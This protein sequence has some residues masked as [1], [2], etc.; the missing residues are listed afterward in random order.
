MIITILIWIY[1]ALLAFV[2]GVSI[3]D[4]F[5]KS[6]RCSQGVEKVSI[7]IIMLTGLSGITLIAEVMNFFIN[8]GWLAQVILLAGAILLGWLNWKKV[9]TTLTGKISGLPWWIFIFFALLTLTVLEF[10]T[11]SPINPDTSIYHAQAIRWIETYPVVPGLGNLHTRLALD[12]TWL[13]LNA[14][15][16][17]RFLGGPSF[18]VLP[19]AFVMMVLAF[20]LEGP[21]R[22]IKKTFSQADI[23]KTILIPILFHILNLEISSPG[24]DLP[25]TLLVWVIF[26]LWLEHNE[27]N[28]GNPREENIFTTPILFCF[29]LWAVTIKLSTL[30]LLL[31]CLIILIFFL[32]NR[33]QS[34]VILVTLIFIIFI[35]WLI[36]NFILSG[37]WIYPLPLVAGISPNADWKI[38]LPEV[39]HLSRVIQ[40]WARLPRVDTE[41]VLAMPLFE[42]LKIW[43][44]SLHLNQKLII[45]GAL[46]SPVLFSLSLLIRSIDKVERTRLTICYLIGYLGL[47]FWLYAGPDIRFGYGFIIITPLIA[48]VPFLHLILKKIPFQH[49]VAVSFVGLVFI[50]QAFVLARS[51]DFSTLEQRLIFPMDYQTYPTSACSL[52]N[53]SVYCADAYYA[54]GYDPFPC[55][56]PMDHNS[57][58]EMRGSTF[59]EGFRLFSGQ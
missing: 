26:L 13:I 57:Q 51:V 47:L 5:G 23:L 31:L 59:R 22:L 6:M 12:S 33:K 15:F 4:L 20:L 7:P 21:Y 50:Y 29:A 35:P 36:R 17:L 1:I 16:S 55:I 45:L 58:V 8:L 19:G 9:L 46:I 27:S 38:P 43:F 24:T 52:H 56:P 11:R 3:I 34:A 39:V 54:C 53:G 14:V 25:A 44:L 28:K 18:H 40:A 32:R 2:Y 10:G 41:I 49:I 37:Y 42:W 30:P 48:A